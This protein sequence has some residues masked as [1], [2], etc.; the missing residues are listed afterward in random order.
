MK[1]PDSKLKFIIWS[2][3]ILIP[4]VVTLLGIIPPLELTEETTKNLYLLPKMNAIIN[5]TTFFVLLGAWIAIRSKNIMLHKTLTSTAII[6]SV[7]FLLSYIVFHFTVGETSF[8][9]DK[10]MWPVYIFILATHIVLSAAIV[11]LVLFTYARGWAM[12]VEKHKKLAHFT[13]P[14][15]LYVTAT[16]VIVYLMISPYYP[17]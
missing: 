3:T 4:V 16:G 14:I 5:G 15:W 13:W 8:P 11:P 12:E 6:L 17:V 10:A 7:V 9:K 2:I 1:L